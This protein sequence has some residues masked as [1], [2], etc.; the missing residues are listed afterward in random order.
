MTT[1]HPE[2]EQDS[3]PFYPDHFKTEFYVVIGIL[4][5]V[6]IVGTLGMFFPVGLQPPADPLNTPLHVKP[7]WYFLALYQLLKFVPPTV[8]GIEG[9]M[10]AVSLMVLAVLI[11]LIWPFLDRKEDSKKAMRIRATVTVVGLI[12]TIVLTIWGE[13]S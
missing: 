8:L 6:F 11:V 1:T 9:P 12:L 3:V 10:F 13:V 2:G 5:L 4:S 7:E